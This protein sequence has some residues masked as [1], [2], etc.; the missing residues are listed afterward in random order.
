MNFNAKTQRRRGAKQFK[1]F[2]SLRLCA[3]ALIPV[4]LAVVSVL[5]PGCGQKESDF[6]PLSGGFG[7]KAKWVGVDS[8]PGAGL[9]YKTNQ[10]KPVVVWPFLT[11]PLLYTNDMG[12]FVGGVPDIAGRFGSSYY[13]AA[14]A[15]G[16]ALEVSEDV[17]KLW[18]ESNH[19]E[20]AKI[21][22]ERCPATRS[23]S[24]CS[25]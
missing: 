2:A 1:T 7:F 18:A 11:G 25:N 20:F 17:L 8:G 10:S 13:F 9:Y 23:F 3:F 15:P 5:A 14:Q 21:A 6:Q 12:F 22:V 19:L 24:K 4:L 16:P